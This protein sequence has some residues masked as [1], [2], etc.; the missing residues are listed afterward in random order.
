[1]EKQN[2]T[3]EEMHSES[4]NPSELEKP[5]PGFLTNYP[6]NQKQPYV[7]ISKTNL[8]VWHQLEEKPPIEAEEG[9]PVKQRWDH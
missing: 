4:F 6:R 5:H 8:S 2:S 7:K 3:V 9:V 1:L